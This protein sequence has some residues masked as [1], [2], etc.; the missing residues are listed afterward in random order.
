MDC[1][2]FL[3]LIVFG[4]FVIGCA[5]TTPEFCNAQT[6]QEIGYG[7]ALAGSTVEHTASEN[8]CSTK[9]APVAYRLGFDFGLSKMC[10]FDKGLFTGEHGQSPAQ[11]CSDPQWDEYQHGYIMGHRIHQTH[12]RLEMISAQ[13]A[14]HRTRLWKLDAD[15]ADATNPNEKQQIEAQIKRLIAARDVE[16]RLLTNLRADVNPL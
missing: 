13:L 11:S 12:S 8:S 6:W 5:S 3:V 14:D 9:G 4:P 2:T 10:T 15:Q 7:D 1:R 16:S